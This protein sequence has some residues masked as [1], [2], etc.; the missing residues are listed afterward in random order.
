MLFFQM[1]FS[2]VG[3]TFETTKRICTVVNRNGCPAGSTGSPPN[4][5]CQD[6]YVFDDIHWYCRPWY[7]KVPTTH[8]TEKYV[9]VPHCG[10]F[11]YGTYL[12][13]FFL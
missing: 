5:K 4:C 9:V 8:V 3:R 11:Q 6:K 12:H 7:L 2:G 13:Y 1:I 10:A